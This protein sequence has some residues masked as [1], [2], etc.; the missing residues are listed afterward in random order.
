VS[1]EP[2]YRAK[3]RVLP[4]VNYRDSRKQSYLLSG[5]GKETISWQHALSLSLDEP[6]SHPWA[7][8]TFTA[9]LIAPGLLFTAP[10]CGSDAK[11]AESK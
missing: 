9:L 11:K 5:S 6:L 1:C 8:F 10:A 7:V 4:T 2:A 3:I